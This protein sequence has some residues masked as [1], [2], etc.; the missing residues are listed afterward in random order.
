MKEEP[1][2]GRIA[3]VFAEDHFDVDQIV[4]IENCGEQD[5]NVLLQVSMKSFDPD[6][7][8]KVRVGDMIVGGRNFG[9][10]HPHYPAMRYMRHL[11]IRAVIAESFAPGFWQNEINMGF[12][13]LACPGIL[14]AVD[15]WHSLEVHPSGR[16]VNLDTGA[17][18]AFQPLSAR[19]RDIID[20]GGFIPYLQKK[21]R[22]LDN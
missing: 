14:S 6:F 1:F 20:A 17:E 8:V 3:Y 18:L 11:G 16:L 2:R 21:T 12:I 5:L 15:R 13:P 9:Y 10:G 22:A 19:Q 7:A 4:G